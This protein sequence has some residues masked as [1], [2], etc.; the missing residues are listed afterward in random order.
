MYL[1]A[2]LLLQIRVK[3]ARTRR[4][5]QLKLP[6]LLASEKACQMALED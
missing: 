6:F 2:L 4:E 3:L 5:L 1:T